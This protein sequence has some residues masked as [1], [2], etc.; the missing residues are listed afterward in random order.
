MKN[1][2]QA[3]PA[4]KHFPQS[5]SPSS[6]KGKVRQH[7]FGTWSGKFPAPP[8]IE[9]G[10]AIDNTG[11]ASDSAGAATLAVMPFKIGDIKRNGDLSGGVV[12]RNAAAA[13]CAAPGN[14]L[15]SRG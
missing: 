7:H 9:K 3:F 6:R 4:E 10:R 2:H 1:T 11:H 8:L 5:G 14:V 13:R 15:P 12:K